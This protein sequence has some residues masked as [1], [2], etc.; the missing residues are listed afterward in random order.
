[1]NEQEY[2]NH[3]KKQTE[4]TPIPDS[5]SPENMKKM[6][7]EQ[8]SHPTS[9]IEKNTTADNN[10]SKRKKYAIQLAV[11]SIA[12]CLCGGIG[13]SILHPK[14][15]T[16]SGTGNEKAA[17][18]EV[19]ENTREEEEETAT[20]ATV[21]KDDLAYETTMESPASYD[22]YYNTIKSAYDEYYNSYATVEPAVEDVE[23]ED[24]VTGGADHIRNEAAKE[25]SSLSNQELNMLDSS[26]DSRITPEDYSKTNTQEAMIDEGDI[27]KTDGNYIYKAS[28]IYDEGLDTFINTLSITKIKDGKLSLE[29]TIDLDSIFPKE[30]GTYAYFNEMYLY[31]NSLILLFEKIDESTKTAIVIYDVS[32]KEKPVQKKILYQSGGY[33]SSRISDGYLYTVSNFANMD[34]TTKKPYSNYVPSI[35]DNLIDCDNIYYPEDAFVHSTFVVTSTDLQSFTITDSKAVPTNGGGLYV[36]SSSIYIYGTIYEE[37][38]KTEILRIGYKDGKLTVGK[39]AVLTGFLYDTF[40]LSEYEGFLRVVA[41]IPANNFSLLRTNGIVED[42]AIPE[43]TA[44]DETRE[45]EA[46]TEDINV[47]YIFDQNMGLASKISGIAPGEQIRSARFLGT[48]GYLVTYENVDPLFSMDLSDPYN[49]EIVGR[50]SIP[51]FSEYLHSYADGLLLGIGQEIEP[52]TQEFLGLK[53]S[54]FDISNPEDV[55]VANQ[56]IIQEAYYSPAEYNH[57]A[58]MIDTKKNIFGFLYQESVTDADDNYTTN[59]YYVTYRY[60]TKN[61]FVQTG[62]YKLEMKDYDVDGIRGV[63]IGNYLYIATQQY[64]V[65]YEI[66]QDKQIDKLS[67]R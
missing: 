60:D 57:K 12:L 50:L 26:M 8:L 65:S 1:M 52:A 14:S 43:S 20:E 36:S 5:I 11:A 15:S 27:I 33:E 40:A 37:V 3:I 4:Q 66:G 23:S 46:L 21:P 53:L 22:E 67:L 42:V 63:Y 6:L 62:K 48:M 31:K 64:I 47:L 61:G 41:T 10:D 28:G 24:M 7:D 51:G 59:N 30:D 39:S 19:A 29:S 45:P 2:M 55:H 58:L 54:M 49:P 35:N 13:F 25:S 44:D 17:Y 32:N 38:T 16:E 18:E 34:Y 9:M 56:S